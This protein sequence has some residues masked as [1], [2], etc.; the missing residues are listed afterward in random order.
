MVH[1]QAIVG[2]RVVGDAV[3][4]TLKF[5]ANQQADTKKRKRG[6]DA[7]RKAKKAKRA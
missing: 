5:E 4:A 1:A 2:V 7:K 3:Y 6:G